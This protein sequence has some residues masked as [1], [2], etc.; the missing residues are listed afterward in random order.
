MT[1]NVSKKCILISKKSKNSCLLKKNNLFKINGSSLIAKI[2][3]SN[4]KSNG[5]KMK[6]VVV[7]KVTM[8]SNMIINFIE[9]GTNS[10]KKTTHRFK[11]IQN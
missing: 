6:L 1:T 4:L 5:E 3:P 10:Q 2:F 8:K 9:L 7:I 11:K